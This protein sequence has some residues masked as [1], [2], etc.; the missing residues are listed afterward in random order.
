[1]AKEVFPF[2]LFLKMMQQQPICGLYSVVVTF[3][4]I[5]PYYF[6]YLIWVKLAEEKE[7]SKKL[8]FLEKFKN[9]ITK[10]VIKKP[11]PLIN[12]VNDL[13][14]LSSKD[15]LIKNETKIPEKYLTI[16]EEMENRELK[17]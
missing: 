13:N 11:N 16:F 5:M 3:L 10:L 14:D 1:M 6:L 17:K 15:A 8:T 12:D 4:L 2:F 9:Q 7:K